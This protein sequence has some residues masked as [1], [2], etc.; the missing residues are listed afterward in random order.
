MVVE[1]MIDEEIRYLESCIREL[2]QS[3]FRINEEL[4]A[5]YEIVK[6]QLQDAK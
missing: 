1:D 4:L 3:E 6:A 5:R 2:E